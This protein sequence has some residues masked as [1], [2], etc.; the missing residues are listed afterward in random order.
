MN[1]DLTHVR[2]KL[3][4]AQEHAQGLDNELRAWIDRKPYSLTEHVNSDSTRYSLILRENERAPFQR[5]TLIASDCLNNF[6]CALD[7]LIYTIAVF[8]SGLNPPPHE[9]TLAFPITDCKTNFDEAVSKGK[10]GEISK[11]VRAVVESLQPYNRPHPE[12]ALPLLRILRD[13]NNTDKHR[14]LKVTYGAVA[15]GEFQLEGQHPADGRQFHPITNEG[16]ELKD[17]TEIIAMTC[18]RPTP[19]MKWGKINLTI[20]VTIWHGKREPTAP[21]HTGQTEVSALL[22][23]L[24]EEVRSIIHAFVK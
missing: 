18:D 12:L 7:Y 17:G 21:E 24:G 13:L 16:A 10:L 15:E 2:A 8:E 20:I 5:W 23:L 6:R 11:P 9:R 22:E 3:A 4:R 14:L 1:L 19:N